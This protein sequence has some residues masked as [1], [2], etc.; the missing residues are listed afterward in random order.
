MEQ[1]QC[2]FVVSLLMLSILFLLCIAIA[3]L[4]VPAYKVYGEGE[5]RRMVGQWIDGKL[6]REINWNTPEYQEVRNDEER[7]FVMFT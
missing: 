7:V 2:W 5:K 1:L 4:Q 3:H 6:L